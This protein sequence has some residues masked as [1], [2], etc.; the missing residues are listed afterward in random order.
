MKLMI[1]DGAST[2][3]VKPGMILER[4]APPN[5]NQIYLKVHHVGKPKRKGG[6]WYLSCL[7]SE[8]P[9]VFPEFCAAGARN[10]DTG[11]SVIDM[12]QFKLIRLPQT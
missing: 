11:I 3:E 10:G 12:S 6:S 4:P 5:S 8:F 9:D 2:Y 1:V 7:R